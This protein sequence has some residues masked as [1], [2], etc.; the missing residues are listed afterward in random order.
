MATKGDPYLISTQMSFDTKDILDRYLDAMQKVVDRHDVLRT[1]IMWENLTTPAQVVLRQATLSITKLSLDPT[2][3]TTA[4]QMVKLTNPREHRISLSQPP[5]IRFVIAQDI[6]GSWN[7]VRLM[8]HIICDNSTMGVMMNEIHVF[9]NNKVHTLLEPQPF[10]N[11]IAQVRSGPSVEVHEQFF[12][13][14]LADIDTPALP[15][16]LSDIHNDSVKVT[17]SHLMLPQGLSDRLRGH[18]KR[19]GVN[20]ATMCHLGWAQVVSKTS[21]QEQVV[22]GTV[23]FGRM[24]GGSGA[25]RAMGLFIN[26]LPI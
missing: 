5:L 4:D 8:H 25:D 26:T 19:M 17:E 6:D 15:Y 2:G 23:L 13:K 3:G 7:V 21:G 14:M 22:I 10:R 16:G 18:A 12:T 24:Q 20:V 9:I 1:A 11:L